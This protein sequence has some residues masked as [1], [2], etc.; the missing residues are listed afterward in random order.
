LI[1]QGDVAIERLVKSIKASRVWQEG[2]N[3]IGIVGDE[4]DYSSIQVNG[5][6]GRF[7]HGERPFLFLLQSRPRT[8]R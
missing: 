6:P 7:H 5:Y 2:G 1:E 8:H 4:N 3:A